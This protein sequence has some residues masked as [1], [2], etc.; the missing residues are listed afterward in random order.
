[1]ERKIKERLVGLVVLL[2][3]AVIFIPMVLDGPGKDEP[4]E[5]RLERPGLQEDLPV[6]RLDLR[7]RDAA[8]DRQADVDPK[9]LLPDLDAEP[10]APAA[11]GREQRTRTE[12]TERAPMQ[13]DEIQEPEPEP[14]SD[15]EPGERRAGDDG[16]PS[17]TGWTAQVGSFS[18]RSNAD[19]LMRRLREEGFEAFVMQYQADGRTMY[20]VRVGL[21]SER[22]R[23]V[24]LA[25]R[26]RD[27]TGEPARPVPHP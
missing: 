19:G 14:E 8:A 7:E 12:V 18:D 24:A 5:R 20:R 3:L 16:V 11:T 26:I 6:T 10:E 2:T 1:M 9:S 25:E 21:E 27:R 23:A 15:P 17:G 13:A 22:D 4:I